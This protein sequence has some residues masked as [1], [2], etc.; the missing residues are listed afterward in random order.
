[1]RTVLGYCLFIP[2]ALLFIVLAFP[3]VFLP[4]SV[5]YENRFYFFL[6]SCMSRAFFRCMGISY[7][8]EG[9]EF[10]PAYPGEPSICIA[11][12][13]SALDIFAL[14]LLLKSYPRVWM[15]KAGYMSV[16]FLGTILSRMHVPLHYTSVYDGVRSLAKIKAL[17]QGRSSHALLF[18]EGGRYV[19]GKIHPF[20]A[21]FAILARK[22]QR[23]VVPVFIKN[24]GSLM[25]PHSFRIAYNSQLVLRV[26]KPFVLQEGETNQAFCARVQA[27]FEK[28]NAR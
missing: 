10:L 13:A 14:E 12:H 18:P 8:I 22:L 2:F 17:V 1:V 27:W 5:R 9:A 6:S 19:D 26:G 7:K 28:E 25:P 21:G 4:T 23:P 3:L 11:N 24:A 15:S 16:P 20:F